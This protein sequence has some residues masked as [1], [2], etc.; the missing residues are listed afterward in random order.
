MPIDPQIALSFQSP[1]IADPTET[2]AK[3]TN[4]ANARQVIQLGAERLKTE[5]LQ[6][7]ETE[8]KRKDDELVTK[9][10]Q[11]AGGDPTKT[12]TNA[13]RNGARPQAV[14]SLQ[15]HFLD[16]AEQTAK[17]SDEDRK[18]QAAKSDRLMALTTQASQ[19]PDDQ[20]AAA[21]PQIR[22]AAQAIDPKDQ[23]LQGLPE[24]PVPKAD[25]QHLQFGLVTHKAVLDQAEEIRKQAAEQRAVTEA[26]QKT[27]AAADTHATS[28][29]ALRGIQ[30]KSDIEAASANALRQMTR[31]DWDAGLNAVIPDKAS[32]L[33][34]R[35]KAEMELALS[36]G[37]LKA[38]QDAIRRGGDQI[39]ATEKAVATARATAPIK[40]EVGTG[41]A[42]ARADAAGL[43][44]DDYARSGEQ[45]IRTG[46]MPSMGRDSVTRGRIVKAGNQWARDNGLN[47]S[48]VVQMQAAYAGD[49]SSLVNFQK[50]RDQIVSFEQTA[51]KNLNLFLDAAAKIPDTGVPWIN[52]PLRTL[53]EKLVGSANMA[54]VNA[55]RQ[56][57]NNE[58]AKV[59]SGGGLGGVLSDSARHEVESFNPRNATLAQTIAVAKVLKQDMANR[60]GAMDATLSD[61]KGRIGGGGQAAASP[62]KVEKWGFD[63]KGNLVKQ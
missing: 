53:N 13:V 50:Q 46:V 44:D 30:A 14:Q 31:A 19:L 17:L 32:P 55:A 3:L 41:I 52:A 47:P 58:I 42:N 37:D 24:Q 48:D 27:Q 49:K 23:A 61:I 40:I 8:L 28:A 20:Y 36:K 15:K 16:S 57:A 25:L 1:K 63:A 5:Q 10:W 2:A 21:W 54:A 59:T 56:V 45:Y 38:A 60:H 33:Y 43:T 6:N 39:G 7:Q 51:Q 35:T 22:V 11:D 29:A 12:V 34:S 4:L 18:A 26:G 9:A 62:A